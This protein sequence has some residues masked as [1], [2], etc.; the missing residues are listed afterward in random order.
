MKDRAPYGQFMLARTFVP[1]KA[2]QRVG[3]ESALRQFAKK[4]RMLDYERDEEEEK[5]LERNE[6]KVGKDFSYDKQP[7][8][9]SSKPAKT[10]PYTGL[11]VFC[12]R[13]TNVEHFF[14]LACCSLSS[15]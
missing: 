6:A 8:V 5:E 12:N 4:Y 10:V 9:V 2:T 15:S 3:F 7:L 1:C 14:M 13:A 11:A